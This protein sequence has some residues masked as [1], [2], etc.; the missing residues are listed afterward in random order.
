MTDMESCVK[1]ADT[2]GLDIDG[3]Q[4][5]G[6][7]A[8]QVL[9]KALFFSE[10]AEA[11]SEDDNGEVRRKLVMAMQA[12]GCIGASPALLKPVSLRRAAENTL[13]FRA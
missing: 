4:A 12:G 11:L 9:R 3:A 2:G 13:K 7:A 6:A 8:L 5:A 1:S 10:V